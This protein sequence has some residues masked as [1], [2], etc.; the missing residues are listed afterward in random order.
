MFKLILKTAIVATLLAGCAEE[1]PKPESA[2]RAEAVKRVA[3]VQTVDP[4]TREVLLQGPSGRAFVIVAGPEVR[5]FDQLEPG[6]R[7]EATYYE[8]VAVSMAD[9]DDPNDAVTVDAA[10]RAKKG[11]KPGLIATQVSDFTVEFLEFNP[12][13]NI[14]TFVTP[15][16]VVHR[17]VVRPEMREFALARE[18]GER[19]HVTIEQAVAILVVEING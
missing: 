18:P 11:A 16:N 14:A 5:N 8:A 7:V 15:D 10:E 1:K 3:T 2:Q 4:D 12:E 6:D 19:V 13:T 17:T 9:T